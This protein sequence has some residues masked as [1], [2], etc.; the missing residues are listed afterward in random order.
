MDTAVSA[1]V[2]K[3]YLADA[4]AEVRRRLARLLDA[5][6]G[7]EIAGEAEDCDAALEGIRASGADIAVLDLHL[8]GG[9]SLELIGALSRGEVSVVVIVLTN[10][11][12]RAFRDACMAAGADFF[13]DKTSEFDAA[14]RAIERIARA[15]G[16]RPGE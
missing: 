15:R 11:T 4:S 8:T 12:A 1:I 16:A 2:S 6:A 3:V 5:I 7:V 10:Y 14:C 9:N 13:F